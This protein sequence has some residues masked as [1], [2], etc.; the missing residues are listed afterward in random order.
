MAVAVN[1]SVGSSTAAGLSSVFEAIKLQRFTELA[2]LL[3]NLE[4]ETA[5]S[6]SGIPPE[7][8][9]AIHLLAHV[10]AD[11][12]NS[13]R[14]VWK[15][16]PAPVKQNNP[17]L[18]AAWKIVKCLWNHEHAAVHEALRSYSWSPEVQQVVSAIAE[19]Y[20]RK[21]LKLLYTAYS[22]ISVSDAAGFLGM[23]EQEVI[24][25]TMQHGWTL[26]PV[27][28]MLTVCPIV[29]TVEQKTDAS[30]L[31]SLTEYVFHLEH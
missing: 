23:T 1:G 19:D 22:T 21:V 8:P 20:S 5:A 24:N 14:F 27:A 4:L 3:D 6:G 13:A 26:D 30:Q 18:A 16:M 29:T 2:D 17:E 7:W 12:L 28:K 9:Y 11:D 25:Y 31:Q 10:V 15:R